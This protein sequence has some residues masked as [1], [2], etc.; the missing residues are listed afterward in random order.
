MHASDAS[1]ISVAV[2]DPALK[3]AAASAAVIVGDAL[4]A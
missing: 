4:M 3:P 2:K 1:T